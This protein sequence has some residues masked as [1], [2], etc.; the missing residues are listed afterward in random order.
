LSTLSFT[1]L[2]GAEIGANSYVVSFGNAALLI[3]CGTHP[4]K[5]GLESLPAFRHITT[6]PQAALISHSHIDHCGA[7]PLFLR[8]CPEAACYATG[9]TVKILDR[10]L[11]NSVS[12]MGTMALE[13]GIP[14]YPLYT[15]AEVDDLLRSM[16]G[17]DFGEEFAPTW[18]SPFRACFHQAGHVLG[19]A[20]I[21]VKAPGHTLFYT[22][23][24]SM[25]HQ[26]LMTAF[27]PLPPGFQ[28]DT[29]VIECTRCAKDLSGR[30][31][32]EEEVMQLSR[33][34]SRVLKG[35]GCV[36]IPSFA[37]GRTQELL[38][39]IARLQESGLVPD[40]PVYASGLGR[41]IYEIYARHEHFFRQGTTLRPL[42]QFARIG[43]VWE[44]AVA[45]D[46][47]RKPCIIVAT[48]GMMIENTPSAMIAQEMVRDKRHG[49]F[50]VGYLDPDTLGHK[51]LHAKPGDSFAFE[52]T[53]RPVKIE[54]ENVKQ[55][56]FSAHAPREDL[57]RLVAQ[58]HPKNIV[59]IHGDPEATAWMCANCPG[60]ARRFVP[61][62][63]VP[64]ALEA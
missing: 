14:D 28:P 19:S 61:E 5:E 53:G 59:F 54:I 33:E 24:V 50:F 12:V 55:F 20:S 22:G 64:I 40:V 36:L 44:R 34:I 29:L 7:L 63:G 10:M 56:D 35:N 42:S 37:L 11:H 6:P 3:D 9:P 23:D 17:M 46:L 27:S 51:L 39:I 30:A 62:L 57:C 31:T 60:D 15:H 21:V 13:R 43:D 4:K 1:A 8:Q 45:R 16:Y 41:A 18:N 2:G 58:L 38:N 49:I 25:T 32:Y 26:E 47:L 52:L 48:S